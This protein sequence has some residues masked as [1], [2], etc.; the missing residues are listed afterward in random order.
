M[1]GSMSRVTIR[2][3]VE[4][5]YAGNGNDTTST[6]ATKFDTGYLLGMTPAFAT[7][8]VKAKTGRHTGGANYVYCDTHVQF[9]KPENVFH[10]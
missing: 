10:R 9:L 8:N 3:Q 4:I 2:R 7:A 5:S 1:A 6:S